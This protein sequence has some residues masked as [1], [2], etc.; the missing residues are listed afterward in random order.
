VNAAAHL[1]FTLIELL[2]V[3]AIIAILAALL[4]PA[5]SR[6]KEQAYTAVCINNQKQLQLAWLM[7]VE[8]NNGKLPRNDTFFQ[9]S[10]DKRSGMWVQGVMSTEK[11][12]GN[13]EPITDNTNI[14]KLIDPQFCTLGSYT[15]AV[16]LYKCP[17]DKSWAII[18]GQRHNRVR[19]YSMN[20][21]LGPSLKFFDDWRARRRISQFVSPPPCDTFVF[22]CEHPDSID[23]G[24]FTPDMHGRGW[25]GYGLPSSLQHGRSGILSFADGHVEKHRWLD[26]RT[27]RPYL[28]ER[29]VGGLMSGNQDV[30]EQKRVSSWF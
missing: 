25:D 29:F 30:A 3:I 12:T 19:S 22:I 2:V 28:H 8:D 11:D 9:V 6:A 27:Y 21:Y 16:G 26:S 7:Y 24:E 10:P 1:G 18:D 14:L 5:L 20:G 23:D 4:L 17:S 15:K 13:V